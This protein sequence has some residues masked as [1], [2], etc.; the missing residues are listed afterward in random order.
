MNVTCVRCGTEYEFDDALVSERGTTVRCTRCAFEFRVRMPRTADRPAERWIV[1]KVTGE[2]YDFV[3]LT[4]LQ[5]AI[6]LRRVSPQDELSRDG[7]T[8]RMLADAEE[9]EAFFEPSMLRA[10]VRGGGPQ[11][12]GGA[13]RHSVG[14]S[15]GGGHSPPVGRVAPD[16]GSSPRVITRS[17]LGA[18][19]GRDFDPAPP[20]FDSALDP[21]EPLPDWLEDEPTASGAAAQLLSSHDFSPAPIPATS[22]DSLP[23][24]PA[25]RRRRARVQYAASPAP[26][27]P[28]ADASRSNPR[29]SIPVNPLPPS[30]PPP[31]RAGGGIRWMGAL[32]LLGGGALLAATVG[33]RYFNQ[34]IDT[35][36]VVVASDTRGKDWVVRGNELLRAGDLEGAKAEFDKAS[37]LSERDPEALTGLLHVELAQA[38]GLWLKIRLL[39]D[40]EAGPRAQ[41][42][43]LLTARF[44]KLRSA[45]EALQAVTGERSSAS[46]A[47]ADALRIQGDL[48][49]ARNHLAGAQEVGREPEVAYVLALLDAADAHPSWPAIVGRLNNAALAERGLGRAHVALIY[50][51]GASGDFAAARQQLATFAGQTE[52]QALL[53]VLQA[54]INR[55]SPQP[56]PSQRA[57]AAP[58]VSE[59]PERPAG[60]AAVAAATP[61]DAIAQAQLARSAGDWQRAGRYYT[62]ALS[63][64]PGNVE[65]MTGLGDVALASGRSA[66]AASHYS[67]ALRQDAN[68]TPAL[69]ALGDLRWAAGDRAAAVELYRRLPS[70]YGSPIVAQRLAESEGAAAVSTPSLASTTTL[71]GP[72]GTSRPASPELQRS[73]GT[74]VDTSDLP[75]YN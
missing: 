16:L 31:S 8:F 66:V 61:V 40:E 29:R 72:G 67:A 59:A 42:E 64:S 47:I 14:T 17:E 9:F 13:T 22:A 52:H 63:G 54:Y 56:S 70:G 62:L 5:Q 69:R 57:E 60:E 1:R 23:A 19:A 4:D 12:Q 20:D 39:G 32:V 28:R 46:W 3:S 53:D 25:T 21:S 74:D 38:D 58:V 37:A 73:P 15:V 65:A 6:H 10:R 18:A 35:R 11:P 33:R 44:A 34:F 7:Q 41:L 55:L 24:G 30:I 26:A 49:A 43:A 48:P 71:G 50:A 36:P 27:A 45:V 68:Y 2:E 51:L 75:E